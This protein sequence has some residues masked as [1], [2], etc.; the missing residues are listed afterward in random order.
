MLSLLVSSK[1]YLQDLLCVIAF[2]PPQAKPS[3]V[4]HLFHYWPQLNPATTDRRGT[5]YKYN[6]RI[7]SGACFSHPREYVIEFNKAIINF[8]NYIYN[9]ANYR[10]MTTRLLQQWNFYHWTKWKR[11]FLNIQVFIIGLISFGTLSLR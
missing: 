10:Y 8:K 6:G 2:G 4:N 7:R 1:H 11:M 9:P 3:A 5:H